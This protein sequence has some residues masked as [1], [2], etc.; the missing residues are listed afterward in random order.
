[1]FTVQERIFIVGSYIRNRSYNTT[2]EEYEQKYCAGTI[3][4][5]SGCHLEKKEVPDDVSWIRSLPSP[6]NQRSI[7]NLN[8]QWD[9]LKKHVYY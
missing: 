4:R 1:M 6:G 7:W 3:S 5:V 9:I 8:A 2:T